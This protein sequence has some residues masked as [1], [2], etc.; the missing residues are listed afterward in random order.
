MVRHRQQ[1]GEELNLVVRHRHLAGEELNLVVRHRHLAGEGQKLVVL[2][3]WLLSRPFPSQSDWH[4]RRVLE[5]A[6]AF[7]SQAQQKSGRRREKFQT[8][9]GAAAAAAGLLVQEVHLQQFEGSK[10]AM[11]NTLELPTV[12]QR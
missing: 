8:G 11:S 3:W 10:G 4:A 5:H 12:Q 7:L 1:A 6:Q 9:F 2:I